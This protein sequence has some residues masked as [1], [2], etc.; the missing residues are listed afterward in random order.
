VN[1]SWDMMVWYALIQAPSAFDVI[2]VLLNTVAALSF[3]RWRSSRSPSSALRTCSL[4]WAAILACVTAFLSR[5]VSAVP[6]LL[7]TADLVPQGGHVVL[8]YLLNQYRDTLSAWWLA[9]VAL[10]PA[11]AILV[12]VTTHHRRTR[13]SR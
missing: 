13:A 2:T 1:M 11:L 8:N 9:A 10:L 7:G 12:T 6:A 4:A 5:L 3:L